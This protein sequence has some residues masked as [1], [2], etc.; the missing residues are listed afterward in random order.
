MKCEKCKSREAT[1]LVVSI[2][3]GKRE[4]HH[5]CNECMKMNNEFPFGQIINDIGRQIGDYYMVD[6]GCDNSD[7][8]ENGVPFEYSSDGFGESQNVIPI[9]LISGIVQIAAKEIMEDNGTVKSDASNTSKKE[10]VQNN[11]PLVV[12]P[13]C[14]MTSQL[15]Q[16]SRKAGCAECYKI[17]ESVLMERYRMHY[18]GK[19]AYHGKMYDKS[20]DIDSLEKELNTAVKDQ[21][22]ERAAQIRDIIIKSKNIKKK[23]CKRGQIE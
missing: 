4:E 22:Y 20:G 18:G 23:R 3:N 5:Y 1:S 8:D 6:G 16:K 7:L 21:N 11:E 14:G 13:S 2:V 12:C 9:E 17:F 19:Q 15:M 10:T